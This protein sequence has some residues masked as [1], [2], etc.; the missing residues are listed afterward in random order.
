MKIIF[1]ERHRPDSLTAAR[2]LTAQGHRVLH[3]DCTSLAQAYARL[4][5]P[6]LLIAALFPDGT[7]GVDE[8]GLSVAMAAQ[9]HNPNVV[10]I[11]LTDSAVFGQGELFAMLSSLRCVLS[12]SFCVRDLVE[13]AGHYLRLSQ[14]AC[15]AS[16]GDV[17][18]FPSLRPT[19]HLDTVPLRA[20]G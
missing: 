16:M 2:L 3:T 1:L 12:R 10:T 4:N 19:Q 18:R 17:Y 15:E 6:D 20:C 5:P 9:F 11:L 7:A 14:G 8:S 13:T